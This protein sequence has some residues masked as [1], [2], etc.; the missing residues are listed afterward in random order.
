[1]ALLF[2]LAGILGSLENALVPP[3]QRRKT[4]AAAAKARPDA[5]KRND[6]ENLDLRFIDA[7]DF[8]LTLTAVFIGPEAYSSPFCGPDAR[9]GGRSRHHPRKLPVHDG[10][11]EP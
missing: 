5:R 7:P 6:A 1:M 4:N 3:A 11:A 2:S 8:F 10:P 9:E